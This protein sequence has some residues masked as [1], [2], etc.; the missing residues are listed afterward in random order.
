[1][2]VV[3]LPTFIII[4]IDFIQQKQNWLNE[5]PCESYKGLNLCLV[6]GKVLAMGSW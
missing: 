3:S 5:K 6:S 4:Y 2:D 1:M